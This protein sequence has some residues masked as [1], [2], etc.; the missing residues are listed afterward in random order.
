MRYVSGDLLA[1]N[2]QMVVNAVNCVGVMGAGLA[3]AFRDRYPAIMRPYVQ[4]CRDGRLRPGMVQVL[5]VIRATGTLDPNGDLFIANVA[6]KDHWKAPSDASWISVGLQRLA[7][8]V[9]KN[10]IRSIAIPKLGA[11]LGGLD[12]K[13]QV[14]P[15]VEKHFAPL[16]A[17]GVDVLVYGEAPEQQRLPGLAV[18]TRTAGPVPRA[19]RS[20]A[21]PGDRDVLEFQGQDRIASNMHPTQVM[22]GD[23][24]TPPRIW[25]YVEVPYVL[26]KTTDR[27]ARE[28]VIA[29]YEEAER[30]KP[31]SAPYMLKK[32]GRSLPLRPDW[33]TRKVPLMR[34]LVRD[35]IRRD[36]A[37]A[38]WLLGTGNGHIQEGNR[39]G[40]TVWGV[41]LVDIPAR[42]IRAG[43]GRNELG[44][45]YMEER[46]LYRAE[47]ERSGSAQRAG[48]APER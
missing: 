34:G 22:W 38:R 16:A 4:A 33:E 5:R 8:S 11:G 21:D 45:I 27:A 14:Q 44:K 6:T 35:R 48:G 25:K 42:G 2:A 3:K 10:G 23:E 13:T 30:T 46:T 15:L 47:L 41:A 17:K 9:E 37:F 39:W 32:I 40:D 36:P 26:A 43:Q 12:W 19:A 7:E 20:A 18:E 24:I 1:G 31:G 28:R 29:A